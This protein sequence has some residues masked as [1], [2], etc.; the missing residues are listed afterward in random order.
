MFRD[1]FS[2]FEVSDIKWPVLDDETLKRLR[3]MPFWDEA[4]KTERVAGMRV[5]LMADAERDPM[6]REM[7]AMQAYEETRHSGILESLMEHCGIEVPIDDTDR[8]RDAEWGFIRMGYGEV[9]DSFF[10]FG[11]FKV[12]GETGFF[13]PALMEIFDSFMDEEARHIVF[14]VNWAAYHNK[15]LKML[16]P[17]F[18]IRRAFGM[19]LQA[20]GR[21][22][23]ALKM[24]KGDGPGEDFVMKVPDAIENDVTVRRL[25]QACLDENAKRLAKYDERLI[26]PSLLPN[27]VR[28]ALQ[29]MPR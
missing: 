19:S 10:A 22:E 7:I 20:Y 12:A 6:I 2:S 28:L 23:T 13:P 9:F 16:K 24:A 4:V 18:A 27:A 11:L 5:R 25:F 3:A 1:T 29:F 26:R 14:F 21:L 8:E 15:N 17:W